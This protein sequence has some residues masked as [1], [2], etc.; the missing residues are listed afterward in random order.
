M[1]QG[2]DDCTREEREAGMKSRAGYLSCY[3]SSE[4]KKHMDTEVDID[5][6]IYQRL[7]DSE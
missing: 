7:I 5:T 6:E 3:L 4:G 1:Q 2:M